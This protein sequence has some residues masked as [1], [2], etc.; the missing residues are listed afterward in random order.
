MSLFRILSLA[1]SF[2][3]QSFLTDTLDWMTEHSEI[4]TPC[5]VLFCLALP[6]LASPARLTLHV[7]ASAV[8]QLSSFS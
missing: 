1:L 3:E 4:E 7:S 6:C 8:G 2:L 5:I